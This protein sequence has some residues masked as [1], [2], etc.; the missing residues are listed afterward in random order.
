MPI[1]SEILEVIKGRHGIIEITAVQEPEN[2]NEKPLEID[3][4]AR[5]GLLGKFYYVIVNGKTKTMRPLRELQ[6]DGEEY[7]FVDD[8]TGKNWLE[9]FL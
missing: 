7:F 2:L 9:K 5:H 8:N 4:V 3:L 6:N 1:I